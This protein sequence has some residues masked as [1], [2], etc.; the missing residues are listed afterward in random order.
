MMDMQRIW[1]ILILLSLTLP[2]RAGV[3]MYFLHN[4]HLGTPRVVTDKNQQV[5]WK[6]HMR[7]FGEMEVEIESIT[8]HRRFPGQRF[9]IESRLHYNYFRDYDSSLGRYIQSDPIGLAGGLNTYAYVGSNPLIYTDPYG[10][11]AINPGPFGRRAPRSCRFECTI[12]FIG[13]SLLTAGAGP[14]AGRVFTSFSS[15]VAAHTAGN[16][17]NIFGWF[18]LGDCISRCDDDDCE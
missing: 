17:N 14:A 11:R 7:P 1:P 18:S 9:D 10:L 4:D 5:V 12:N 13:V 16:A 6:G 15:R 3:E 8:N 2:A